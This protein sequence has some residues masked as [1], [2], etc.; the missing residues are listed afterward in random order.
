MSGGKL[1]SW[2]A[3]RQVYMEAGAVACALRGTSASL[4]R[5]MVSWNGPV[6][7]QVVSHHTAAQTHFYDSV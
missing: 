6:V 7:L 1:E 5:R 4:N 2:S 3:A